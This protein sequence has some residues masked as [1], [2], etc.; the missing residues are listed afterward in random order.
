MEYR[1]RKYGGSSLATPQQILNAAKQ[2]ADLHMSGKKV[3]VVV[4]AMG[5]ST[6]T[7][8]ELA[9]KVNP[10]PARRELDMLLTTGERVSMSLMSMALH[11]LNCPAISFTGSQAGVLTSSTHRDATILDIKP[12]RV[13]AS[14]D[15]NR[16]VVLAGFQ[17]VDPKTKE[18]TTLGRG[19]SDTTAIAAA[20][21]FKAQICEILK[22][23]DGVYSADPKNITTA[24]RLKE[25]TYNDLLDMCFWGSQILHYRSVA[26]AHKMNLP[27]YIG[28]S[29]N[30]KNGTRIVK[31]THMYESNEILS[32]NSHENVHNYIFEKDHLGSSI[33]LLRS[34]IEAHDLPWPQILQTKLENSKVSVLLTGEREELD[35]LS[36][37]VKMQKQVHMENSTL[38]TVTMTAYGGVRSDTLQK[39]LK[40]LSE[41][42][43]ETYQ[44]I[45]S[46]LSLTFVVKNSQRKDTIEILHGM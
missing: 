6:D 44:T 38:S 27:L 24:R 22:D 46:T 39:A 15:N 12:T 42:S 16:I 18:I 11:R 1:I 43:I 17:G 7:L 9:Q 45:H 8:I 31:D 14:L 28:S 5:K 3:I 33:D 29:E 10:T 13:K 35:S 25:I 23:V 30:P 26:L 21:H 2:V 32:V 20:S 34:I 40:K 19:G 41:N 37:V 36:T 4:S